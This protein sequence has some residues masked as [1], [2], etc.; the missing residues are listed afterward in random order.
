MLAA[1]DNG[2]AAS[3][4]FPKPLGSKNTRNRSVLFGVKCPQ[5][6]SVQRLLD[7]SESALSEKKNPPKTKQTKT[8]TKKPLAGKCWSL[9]R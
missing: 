5:E 1:C 2:W 4:W 6:W 7:N 9:I 3:Q 8:Q